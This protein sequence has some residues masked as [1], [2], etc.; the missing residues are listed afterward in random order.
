MSSA[1]KPAVSGC[2]TPDGAALGRIGEVFGLSQ[3]ELAALFGVRRQAVDQ[4][5][6]RG[7]P[8]ARQEK[9]ATVGAIADLLEATLKVDRIPGVV[10]REATA[11]SG[12]SALGAI[13]DDDQDL[14]LAELRD[15]F[16]WGTST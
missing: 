15:A 13:G 12:R 9:L 6:V 3:V 14:V 16:D 11:Y 1:E 5:T 8:A 4:W 7:V 10:R 2:D